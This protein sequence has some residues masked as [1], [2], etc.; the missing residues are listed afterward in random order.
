M[1]RRHPPLEQVVFPELQV[2]WLR[3]H[4]S[5][6][7]VQVISQ[8]IVCLHNLRHLQQLQLGRRLEHHRLLQQ[9]EGVVLVEGLH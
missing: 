6:A 7:M 2:V 4:R 9:E 3:R 5:S 1:H 8:T